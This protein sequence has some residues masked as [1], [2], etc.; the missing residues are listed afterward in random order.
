MSF[1]EISPKLKSSSRD[2]L[3]TQIATHRRM[4]K[5]RN[6]DIPIYKIDN[7]IYAKISSTDP[8]APIINYITSELFADIIPVAKVLL[9]PDGDNNYAYSQI[10]DLRNN[11]Q[12]GISTEQMHQHITASQFLIDVITNDSDRLLLDNAEVE[13]AP[14]FD[15]VHLGEHHNII[16]DSSNNKFY[17]FDHGDAFGRY[18]NF[19]FRLSQAEI[20]E[21]I[22]V[23]IRRL[24]EGTIAILKQLVDKLSRKLI[25]QDDKYKKLFEGLPDSIAIESLSGGRG[26]AVYDCI[27]QRIAILQEVLS[28]NEKTT[29]L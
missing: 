17:F 22:N 11:Y 4:P 15:N 24:D 20:A 10:V 9:I 6:F 23:V 2:G 5:N 13:L 16:V 19:G 3:P 21:S 18:G 28:I 26:N 7:K 29:D 25:H 1:N 12:E 14:F 27:S 8:G